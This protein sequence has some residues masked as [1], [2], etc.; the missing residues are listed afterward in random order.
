MLTEDD[1]R[2]I[3][4]STPESGEEMHFES[5]SFCVNKKIFCTLARG[6][7]RTTIKL[8]PEDQYNLVAHDPAAISA[9]PGYWGKKGWTEVKF[10]DLDEDRLTTLI[11]LAWAAV[12]P[13]RLARGP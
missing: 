8:T 11:R 13:K 6:A 3:A 4:L 5:A 7:D 2:R 1:V 12:A 10:P 9:V